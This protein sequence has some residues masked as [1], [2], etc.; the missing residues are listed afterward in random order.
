MFDFNMCVEM[1]ANEMAFVKLG[2][3]LEI[4]NKRIKSHS[5]MLERDRT[6]EQKD[7]DKMALAVLN[8]LK[9]DV[10]LMQ[11]RCRVIRK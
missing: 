1:Y 7:G 10:Q 3:V 8:E 2:E 4:I 5:N 11:R 9:L 6:E